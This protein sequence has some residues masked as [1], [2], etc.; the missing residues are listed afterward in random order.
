MRFLCLR[1]HPERPAEILSAIPVEKITAF[2][3]DYQG[4]TK[5]VSIQVGGAKAQRVP[6]RTV[7]ELLDAIQRAL[8]SE[9]GTMTFFKGEE[10]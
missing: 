1:K 2:G 4:E 3:V 6:G 7:D 9:P 5:G 10:P 8:K